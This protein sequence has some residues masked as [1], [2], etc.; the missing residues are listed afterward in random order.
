MWSYWER[1]G[2]GESAEEKPVVC[3]DHVGRDGDAKAAEESIEKGREEQEE[4]KEEE[5]EC[6]TGRKGK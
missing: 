3:V 5:P 6:K 2:F 4:E 1:L